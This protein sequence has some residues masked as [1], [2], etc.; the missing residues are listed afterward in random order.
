M[1]GCAEKDAASLDLNR[2]RAPGMLI[3]SNFGALGPITQEN[4]HEGDGSKRAPNLVEHTHVYFTFDYAHTSQQ[5]PVCDVCLRCCGPRV[6]FAVDAVIIF[7]PRARRFIREFH[8]AHALEVRH[9]HERRVT[10]QSFI[11][12]LALS[13]AY[14]RLVFFVFRLLFAQTHSTQKF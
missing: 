9:H 3:G 5:H 4:S 11:F 1:I 14:V 13:S 8:L 6:V 7:Q 12:S 10:Q 2:G